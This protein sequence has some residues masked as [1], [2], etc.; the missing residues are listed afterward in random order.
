MFID[1]AE[2]VTGLKSKSQM[3]TQRAYKYFHTSREEWEVDS[4]T[5]GRRFGGGG[6]KKNENK[7]VKAI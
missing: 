2:T 5:A 4:K 6:V 7:S 3:V 1:V